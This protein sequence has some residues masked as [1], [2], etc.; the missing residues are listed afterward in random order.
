MSTETAHLTTV[1]NEVEADI[2]ISF[3]V[4]NGIHAFSERSD[5]SAG[6]YGVTG[7]MGPTEVWVPAP[8]LAAAQD[9]LKEANET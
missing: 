4:S 3:L 7:S 2:L 9:L 8:D 1:P 6:A 5:L